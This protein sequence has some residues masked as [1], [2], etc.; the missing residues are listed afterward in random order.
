[1]K[2]FLILG[3]AVM[4]VSVA[5]ADTGGWFV[6]EPANDAGP[7][8]IG[9][10][11]WLEKPAGKHGRITRVGDKL[12]YHGQ[13]IKLWGLNLCYGTCAP[14]KALADKR[15]AFYPKFGINT[16][17]LHK[18]VDGP[19]WAGI[20]SKA[21]AAEYDPAGL[22]RMDYQV[23][24]FKA[25]GIYV[26][27]SAH[28]G[29][30]TAG[31]AD[32]RDIPFIEEF[33]KF[34]GKKN[35]IAVPHSAIFYS[36][37]IQALHIRQMVNLLAH[38]NP[39][40]GLTYAADPVIA[41]V[42]IVNEQSILFFTSTAPLKASATLRRQVGAR[43]CA[44]LKKKYGSPDGLVK[45]WG[46]KALDS[47]K[48]EGFPE[49]E[50]LEQGTILPVGNP[51]YW[52]PEQLA[53]AQAYRKQRLL[54]SLQFLSELQAEFYARYI[55]AVRAT[56][57]TGELLGS[58]WQ[59]GRAFSHFANLHTDYEVGTID[60]HNYFGGGK[61]DDKG[62]VN[63]A[64]MLARA[65]SGLFSSGLQQVADRPFMLSEWIHCFP[66]EWGVEG[67]A[68][69]GA[70]GFGL[71]GWDAS[72]M[73]QNGDSGGFSR[74]LGGT[75]WDVMAPQ[76]LGV[77]PA[78]AR[79]VLRGDVKETAPLAVRNVHVPS[80]FA[81]KISF[82]DKI[83]QGYDDKELDSTKV[84]ARALAVAR[85]VVAF[86]PTYQ[87]TPMFDLRPFEKAGQLVS[88]TG[89][90]RWNEGREGFFTMDTAATKAVVGFA[91]GQTCALTGITIKPES[92]FS[93]IY[94][95]APGQHETIA[96][97]KAL[98]IVAMARA[99]NTGMQFND[100]VDRLLA[101]GTA[102]VLLEPVKATLTIPGKARVVLLDH[103]GKRTAK[104]LPIV[105]GTF[106]IDGARD[107]TPYYLAE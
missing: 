80:L 25:A 44:W 96:Q 13:P 92:R 75:T 99:R 23:A 31:P 22:E 68:I 82:D 45:A 57:Y 1:M 97:A 58:N 90:L 88:A 85:S 103:D 11:D 100:A 89:Q 61:K 21:S 60:R 17:R 43:F 55:K 67:P 19:G 59:A 28:F 39:H 77:F 49:A 93:A 32:K 105:N 5:G 36:P 74:A 106:T 38:K 27:L 94:V 87:E 10:E 102:P 63:N 69:I 34:D 107:K 51:W 15:A 4:L 76:I 24:K 2:R 101:K 71:Q 56:G 86:T 70:Y 33:G 35:R 14:D 91:N 20:Q 29:T 18:F 54:D 65:G 42:E 48:G 7:S 66:N 53:G 79:Q 81:G 95:T 46:A 12:I 84:P 41:V 52:E 73:F 83:K 72:Y 30:I 8:A 16:V 37:E 47:F 40:T 64:S 104:T 3:A 50:S 62:A 78:V 9:M 6:F 26:N 98:L